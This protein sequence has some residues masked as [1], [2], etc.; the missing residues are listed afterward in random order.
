MKKKILTITFIF[1]LVFNIISFADWVKDENGKYKYLDAASN[2]YVTNNWVNNGSG[3][4]FLD[5]AGN[6][7]AGWYL[8]NGKYYLF[9]QNYLMQTGFADYNGKTYYLDPK[10]GQMVTGWIQVNNN[11]V[12]DY[13]YFA[14]DGTM[15]DSWN[16]IGDKWFYFLNGKCLVNT[17][18]EVNGLWY[19]FGLNGAMDTGW[20]SENSK[21]YYFS[22]KT[23]A[24]MKGWVQDNNGIEYYLS[25]IDGSL[26]VNTT[27][28]IGG[29]NYTF[30]SMGRCIA[31]DA[32]VYMGV[33][34]G[35]GIGNNYGV[36]LGVSPS[37]GVGM[38]ITS[39]EQQRID[40]EPLE[41]GS[42]TGPK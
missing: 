9:D 35:E 6:A 32:G 33:Y 12:L 42:T 5:S 18:A 31:K 39:F 4:Y 38:G 27:A 21:M 20:V 3:Y 15:L 16:K 2:Q 37:L 40:S 29:R 10:T 8:I 41:A 17:F 11:G 26:V 36:N 14:E 19:H 13:Y 25:D 28:Q 7:V 23:G 22:S 34:M 24:M 1:C 30:D